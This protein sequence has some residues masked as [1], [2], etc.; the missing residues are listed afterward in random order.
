[1][2]AEQLRAHCSTLGLT[3]GTQSM[4]ASALLDYERDSPLMSDPST[5]PQLHV[6]TGDTNSMQ[7]GSGKQVQIA[8]ELGPVQIQ[9][10]VNG[11]DIACFL[12]T[13]SSFTLLSNSFVKRAACTKSALT[14]NA[15]MCGVSGTR[16][17]EA[18]RLRDVRV[19]IGN[20]EVT[21]NTAI[22]S[23][24]P[25]DVQLGMDFFAQA[26]LAEVD[27]LISTSPPSI[28]TVRPAEGSNH[29][30]VSAEKGAR[31]DEQLRFYA[32]DGTY[33]FIPLK[34]SGSKSKPYSSTVYI[35]PNTRMDICAHCGEPWPALRKCPVCQKHKIHTTYCSKACQSAAWP[36]HKL[37]P[38][39]A[40]STGDGC[41]LRSWK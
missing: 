20:V 11:V 17:A 35:D 19:K 6:E 21:L 30:R 26:V 34:H 39:H 5:Y 22:S 1:M 31:K 33:A 27:V 36:Q 16:L 3:T 40:C 15:F 2:T 7:L 8:P 38:P 12:S 14:S 29:C 28:V 25:R 10:K 37:T 41:S 23:D 4:M 32:A 13:T 9:A 18:K 24:A